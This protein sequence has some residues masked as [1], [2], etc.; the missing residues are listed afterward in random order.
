M[1]S[2]HKWIAVTA[3]SFL[4]LWLISGI[5]M[6]VSSDLLYGFRQKPAAP[7]DIQQITTTPAEALAHLTK[8]LDE[9]HEV[10][11][12]GL[13]KIA[14]VV[15]YRI[16]IAG[17]GS[18]LIEAQSGQVF[19]I[20]PAIVEQIAR[21][22]VPSETRVLEIEHTT[23]H[24]YAYQW[25]PLPA[26]R[27]VFAN[28]HSTAYYVSVWDGSILRSDRWSRIL[29]AIVSLHDFRPVTLFIQRESIRIGLLV[30]LSLVGIATAVTGYYLAVSRLRP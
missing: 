1:Y 13:R 15:I 6:V 25:G 28:D 22:Y 27:I 18:H 19:T 4:L 17:G 21:D 3:G 20:T 29:G 12:V 7:I 5:V 30:L 26:F 9:S 10:T 11:S 16:N 24:S 23:Q 8:V 2:I 14:G